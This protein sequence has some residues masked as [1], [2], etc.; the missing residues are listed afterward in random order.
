MK[1]KRY[2][3]KEWTRDQPCC[4]C[5]DSP[6]DPDHNPTRGGRGNMDHDL[7]VPLCRACHTLKGAV[8]HDTFARTCLEREY[9]EIVF[10]NFGKYAADVMQGRIGKNR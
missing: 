8:G 9:R 2:G 7:V 10:E 4:Y 5:G 1:G 3:F 6:S